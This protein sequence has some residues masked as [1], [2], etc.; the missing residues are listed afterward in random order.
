WLGLA[1]ALALLVLAGGLFSLRQGQD[2]APAAATADVPAGVQPRAGGDALSAVTGTA[3]TVA[4]LQ[5]RRAARPDDADA[6]ALAAVAY[7]QRARETNDPSW[8]P[9]AQTLLDQAF[10][11]DPNELPALLGLGSLALSRH[12]FAD[13]LGL[14][15]RALDLSGGASPSALATIGDAQLEL[16]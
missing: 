6:R 14:G 10:R 8:Y 13:A 3:K 4:E 9:K 5:A 12:A 11:Q 16:G 7:L 2:P 15:Q 1:A